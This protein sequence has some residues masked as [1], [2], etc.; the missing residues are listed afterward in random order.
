MSFGTWFKKISTL[1]H[2]KRPQTHS[3]MNPIPKAQ[4]PETPEFNRRQLIQNIGKLKIPK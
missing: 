4:I 1:G 2:W 3:I